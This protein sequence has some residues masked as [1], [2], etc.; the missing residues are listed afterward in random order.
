[1]NIEKVKGPH[2]TSIKIDLKLK[3]L[4]KQTARSRYQTL[5]E[6]VRQLI[7]ADIQKGVAKREGTEA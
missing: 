1:M 6:Y 3:K 7:W 2:M 5:S 4:A